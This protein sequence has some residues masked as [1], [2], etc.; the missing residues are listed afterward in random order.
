MEEGHSVAVEVNMA[1]NGVAA[2]AQVNAGFGIA[3]S[4]SENLRSA[5]ERAET[6][7]CAYAGSRTVHAVA[8]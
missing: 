8:A 1:Y 3:Q 7:A 6:Q 4:A 2:S 5:Y